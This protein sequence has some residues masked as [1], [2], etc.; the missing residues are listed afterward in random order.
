MSASHLIIII[1]MI[2]EVAEVVAGNTKYIYIFYSD[3]KEKD[4]MK[5]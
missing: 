2:A 5:R 1:V 4:I 3:D